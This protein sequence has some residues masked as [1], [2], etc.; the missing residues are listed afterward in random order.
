[1]KLINNKKFIRFI[2]LYFLIATTNSLKA[3]CNFQSAKYI[4]ELNDN[5]SIKSISIKVKNSKKF[6]NNLLK[7]LTT[8]SR[9]IP[10]KLRKKHKADLLVRCLD[11]Y[12][13]KVS[14]MVRLYS[15]LATRIVSRHAGSLPSL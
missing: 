5:N 8:K 4:D 2:I 15:T 6:Y 1:M 12:S 9:N 7:I 3:K 11:I 10:P 13:N 14:K